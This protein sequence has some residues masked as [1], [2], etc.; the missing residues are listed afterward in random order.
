VHE[1][2]QKTLDDGL[3][4]EAQLMEQLFNSKDADEGL[5]AFVEKRKPEF[6]GA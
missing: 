4:L 6:V 5:H 1:G 2:G 3:A